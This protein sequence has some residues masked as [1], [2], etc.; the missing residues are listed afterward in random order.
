MI[1]FTN[2]GFQSFWRCVTSTAYRRSLRY[3]KYCRQSQKGA[4]L[5]PRPM[6][7]RNSCS[8]CIHP[9][10]IS[11]NDWPFSTPSQVGFYTKK[12]GFILKLLNV[13]EFR[14]KYMLLNLMIYRSLSSQ[15]RLDLSFRYRM[16]PQ[17]GICHRSTQDP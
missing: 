10:A 1:L 3:W 13:P 12:I 17:I 15:I 2:L 6:Y 5:V 11:F 16:T 8:S 14:W 7:A 9:T 4:M